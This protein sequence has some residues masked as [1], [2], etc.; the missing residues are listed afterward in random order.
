MPEIEPR[1]GVDLLA[2]LIL[3]LPVLGLWLAALYWYGRLESKDDAEALERVRIRNGIRRPD[4]GGCGDENYVG[5]G[6]VVRA[7]KKP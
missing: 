4:N 1:D 3:M 5:L 7:E 6:D 2:S